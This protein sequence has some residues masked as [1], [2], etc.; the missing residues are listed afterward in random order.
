MVRRG[1]LRWPSQAISSADDEHAESGIE[2]G[3]TQGR[4]GL[5][6]HTHGQP[7]GEGRTQ[8]ERDGVEEEFTGARVLSIAGKA[9]R[10]QHR[11][12]DGEQHE[13]AGQFAKF[14]PIGNLAHAVKL[15]A[16]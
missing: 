6:R 10:S 16:Q 7:V 2:E 9:G 5:Q 1:A 13:V 12:N 3:S 4:A 8:A 14:A 11:T 15:H